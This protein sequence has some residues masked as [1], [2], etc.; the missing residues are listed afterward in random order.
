MKPVPAPI[1]FT[2]DISILLGSLVGMMHT[3]KLKSF[4]AM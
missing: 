3:Q 2:V 1:A 4:F